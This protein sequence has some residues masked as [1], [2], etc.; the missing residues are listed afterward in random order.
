M[1]SISSHT[2]DLL[3]KRPSFIDGIFSILDLSKIQS[4]YNMS[5]TEAEA[6]SRAIASD[7]KAIGEDMRAVIKEYGKN[8]QPNK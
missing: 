4:R 3:K 1:N 5:K 8:N 2:L 6:D 7:W